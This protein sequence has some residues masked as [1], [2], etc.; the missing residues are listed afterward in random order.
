MTSWTINDLQPR[1]TLP[2]GIKVVKE[3]GGKQYTLS[4]G[5]TITHRYFLVRCGCGRQFQTR[6]SSLV[7]AANNRTRDGGK[8]QGT[9]RCSICRL[10]EARKNLN[11]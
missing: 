9:S 10:Q 8:K 4:S 5:Q 11:R 1:T 7:E 2:T 6:G 3:L